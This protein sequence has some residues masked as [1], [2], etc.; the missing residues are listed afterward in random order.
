V[1]QDTGALPSGPF[2]TAAAIQTLKGRR[3]FYER[4]I[5]SLEIGNRAFAG[6]VEVTR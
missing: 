4:F 3:R 2:A 5:L 1:S 6:I